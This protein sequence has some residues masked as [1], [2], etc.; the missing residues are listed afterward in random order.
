MPLKSE[1]DQPAVLAFDI[2]GTRIK[3]GIVRGSQMLAFHS[4]LLGRPHSADDF[5]RT[6]LRIGKG[7]REQHSV[8]A[9]GISIKGI[10]DTERGSVTEVKEALVELV[11]QPLSAQLERSFD[12]PV[13]LENDA[14]MYTLGE[15][16]Y[17]AG[18]AVE[19]LV[20]L[21]LGTGVGCGV[22]INRRI[23]RG[24]RGLSGILGGH[25][26]VQADGPRCNCGNIGCLEAFIGTTAFV[27]EARQQAASQP[28]SELAHLQPLTPRVIFHAAS[29]GDELAQ[30]LVQRFTHYLGAGVVSLIHAYGPEL[31]VL[32]GGIMGAATQILPAVQSYVAQHT[33]ALLEQQVRVV[34][35][36]L[37]DSAALLG[38]AA[39]AI[40]GATFMC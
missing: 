22:A 24:R 28:R 29:A 18:C 1:G 31:V 40:N 12:L 11:G 16:L 32:G 14:R 27:E 37:G 13:M 19:N 33:W 36:D 6:L 35:A 10:V 7:L 23:L 3:A 8:E 20:C 39:L 38:A 9:V 26:S 15:L 25:I 34:E 30:R 17:G 5:V 4:E 2:G 21:T